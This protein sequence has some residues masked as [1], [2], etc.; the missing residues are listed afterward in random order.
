M[1]LC[2]II[3]FNHREYVGFSKR[4]KII[5]PYDLRVFI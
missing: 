2:I 5:L 3:V 4:K 1:R